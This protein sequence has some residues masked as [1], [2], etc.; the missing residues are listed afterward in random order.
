MVLSFFNPS[1][2]KLLVTELT[3]NKIAKMPLMLNVKTSHQ[4]KYITC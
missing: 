1:A 4:G 3:N 2:S